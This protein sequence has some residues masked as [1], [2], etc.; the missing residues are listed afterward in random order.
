[1]EVNGMKK[2]KMKDLKLEEPLKIT[3]QILPFGQRRL[4]YILGVE[5][6]KE[7]EHVPVYIEPTTTNVEIIEVRYGKTREYKVPETTAGV[8]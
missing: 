7:K 6:F 1:M 8:G 4:N 5:K 3:I 2:N